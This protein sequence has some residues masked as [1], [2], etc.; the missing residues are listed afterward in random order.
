MKMFS[1]V[2]TFLSVLNITKTL[3]FSVAKFF[4]VSLKSKRSRRVPASS[5]CKL[6]AIFDIL[7]RSLVKFVNRR[8]TAM[9]ITATVNTACEMLSFLGR[10]V[11][12]SS[13]VCNADDQ[14]LKLIPKHIHEEGLLD[15]SSSWLSKK[16]VC[17]SKWVAKS[18]TKC[19]NDGCSSSSA[20]GRGGWHRGRYCLPLNDLW[21]WSTTSQ[22]TY[23]SRSNRKNSSPK[24]CRYD[25]STR[26]RVNNLDASVTKRS[27]NDWQRSQWWI[28]ILGMLQQ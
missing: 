16:C 20:S 17:T 19:C 7:S 24:N 9:T 3:S 2:E 5:V 18:S 4:N 13:W 23:R 25:R 21:R 6:P 12:P 1:S 26:E 11:P 14:V 10:M 8:T 27:T 22:N 15:H 28:T